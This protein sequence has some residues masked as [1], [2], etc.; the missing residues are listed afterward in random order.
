MS[1]VIAAEFV[2]Y[3]HTLELL[4]RLAEDPMAIFDFMPERSAVSYR[5]SRKHFE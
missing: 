4:G 5:A 2:G 1:K 3:E